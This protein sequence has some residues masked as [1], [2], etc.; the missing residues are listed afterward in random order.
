LMPYYYAET[1]CSRPLLAS[2]FTDNSNRSN[3]I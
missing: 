3:F 1:G 2:L